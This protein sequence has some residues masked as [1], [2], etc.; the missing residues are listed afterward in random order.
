MTPENSRGNKNLDK[1][2]KDEVETDKD[3]AHYQNIDSGKS[4]RNSDIGDSG[5]TDGSE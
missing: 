3:M 1:D 4:S 2:E 5:N